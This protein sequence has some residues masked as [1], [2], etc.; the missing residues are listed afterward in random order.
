MFNTSRLKYKFI[1]TQ[2]QP[3]NIIKQGIEK[4]PTKQL[5]NQ[6]VQISIKQKVDINGMQLQ[7]TAQ[8][9]NTTIECT[10]TKQTM[11]TLTKA[12]FDFQ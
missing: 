9:D 6:K 11:Q 4:Q 1:T 8:I 7:Y 12:C 3:K 2:D 10:I 5:I